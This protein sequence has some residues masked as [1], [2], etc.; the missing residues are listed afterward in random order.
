M[1]I[2]SQITALY[3]RSICTG[4]KIPGITQD[5]YGVSDVN[6]YCVKLI[7][8]K[9]QTKI[10]D[11]CPIWWKIYPHIILTIKYIAGLEKI[12]EKKYSHHYYKFH[13]YLKIILMMMIKMDTSM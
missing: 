3:E 13:L 8:Q 7:F 2:L 12:Q 1:V 11:P 5:I 4:K 10:Q 6:Y 9:H